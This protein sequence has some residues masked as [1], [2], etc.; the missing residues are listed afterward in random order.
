MKRSTLYFEVSQ[1]IADK[2]FDGW[3]Y[4]VRPDLHG[5]FAPFRLM[6]MSERVWKEGDGPIRFIKHRYLPIGSATVDL[7]E[8]MWIKLKAHEID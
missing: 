7:A 2:E 3:R 1:Y 5:T 6:A 8:F 4:F